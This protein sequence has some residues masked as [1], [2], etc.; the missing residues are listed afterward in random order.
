[1]ASRRRRALPQVATGVSAA[2]S[3]VLVAGCLLW[4]STVSARAAKGPQPARTAASAAFASAEDM[5]PAELPP[6]HKVPDRPHR[7]YPWCDRNPEC[8]VNATLV[9]EASPEADRRAR[10]AFRDCGF[11]TSQTVPLVGE[12]FLRDARL[13]VKRYFQEQQR[14]ISSPMRK[15]QSVYP[16]KGH[17]V[18]SD[19]SDYFP[20]LRYPF[21]ESMF[22]T[23]QPAF[24]HHIH[25]VF[26]PGC[27]ELAF[28]TVLT[29]GPTSDG[30]HQDYHSDLV[31]SAKTWRD[32]VY[33]NIDLDAYRTGGLEVISGCYGK[34]A[35]NVQGLDGLDMGPTAHA[36]RAR[37]CG[38]ECLG[39]VE[40]LRG[41]GGPRPDLVRRCNA[42]TG[43]YRPGRPGTWT[44]YT[45]AVMHRGRAF[46][47][48]ETN[49]DADV[50]GGGGGRGGAAAS[51]W[52]QR[53]RRKRRTQRRRFVLVFDLVERGSKFKPLVESY[54]KQQDDGR[55]NPRENLEDLEERRRWF[56]AYRKKWIDAGMPS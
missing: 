40:A 53:L 18:R 4:L 41:Q 9:T 19:R 12:E 17:R 29:N 34:T 6:A 7:H 16:L 54:F 10:V 39:L 21:D 42:K 14:P 27:C 43:W 56:N 48:P 26:G 38:D 1:M 47:A 11:L 45:P 22:A 31:P 44:F 3:R 33:V 13:D 37:R 28:M 24:W 49:R 2:A 32:Q 52:M 20:P 30:A 25:N 50:S 15:L 35:G 36:K 8:G 51:R 5:C 55:A 46:E 23:L